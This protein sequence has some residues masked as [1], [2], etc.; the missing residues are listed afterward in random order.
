MPPT[1]LRLAADPRRGLKHTPWNRSAHHPATPP[2]LCTDRFFVPWRCSQ[3]LKSP[4]YLP[5]TPSYAPHAPSA[6]GSS[7]LVFLFLS[8]VCSVGTIGTIFLIL[9]LFSELDQLLMKMYF[10]WK[11]YLH[12]ISEAHCGMHSV[13]SSQSGTNY[14]GSLRRA[15]GGAGRRSW[16]EKWTQAQRDTGRREWLACFSGETQCGM[17]SM[18]QCVSP[19]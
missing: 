3:S 8:C 16:K 14:H 11:L 17:P 13:S 12:T 18:A 1:H 6:C 19:S 7:P 10:I 9:F 4:H 2:A 5:P 15:A